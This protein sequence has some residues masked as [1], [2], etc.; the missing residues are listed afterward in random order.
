MDACTAPDGSVFVADWYDAGV[1][2]HAFSDQTTGRI[3]RVAPKAGKNQ[4]VK[5]D[6][7]SLEGLIT[8]LKS[9]TI[10]TQ[11]AARRALIER[12]AEAIESL[13]Q[14]FATGEPVL[15]ARALFVLAAIVGDPA[16]ESALKDADPQ[17]R[18]QAVRM[19]GRDCRENGK[20]QYTKPEAKMSCTGTGASRRSARHGRRP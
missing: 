15:R 20:V 11:D 19:L 3:F 2:G 14:L 18:E 8:A 17:I 1:G 9:P 13:R 7:A 12:G 4:K 6:F 5:A 10:A 16:A